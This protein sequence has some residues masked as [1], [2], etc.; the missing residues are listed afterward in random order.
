VD[1]K[2]NKTGRL[3]CRECGRQDFERKA[4]KLSKGDVLQ[5]L[6]LL[7]VSP[8][9]DKDRDGATAQMDRLRPMRGKRQA[10]TIKR[11]VPAVAS[12]N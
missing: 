1:L 3:N 7:L 11:D 12:F 9:I 10:E 5:R 8:L 2:R 4:A 6:T